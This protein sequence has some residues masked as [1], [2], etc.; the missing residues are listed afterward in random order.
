MTTK[1]KIYLFDFDGVLCDS[2]EECMIV[3]YN[4]Y[5]GTSITNADEI[6]PEGRSFFVKNRYL[7]RPAYEYLLLW[8]A[9]SNKAALNEEAFE[10][11]RKQHFKDSKAFH[12]AF[13]SHRGTLRKDIEHWISLHKTYES[14][15]QLMDIDSEDIYIVTNKDKESVE[16]ISSAHGYRHKIRDIY[17]KEISNDKRVLIK[18]L[19]AD[20]NIDLNECELIFVDDNTGH[21]KDV[22]AMKELNITALLAKWGYVDTTTTYHFKQI[23]CLAEISNN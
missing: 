15:T 4:A 2:I 13:F 16:K 12:D 9:Y 21:L 22:G 23:N 7:V 14:T 11:L 8:E 5:Y 6:K 18:K 17:S 19:V 10:L 20:Y 3:S 1:K